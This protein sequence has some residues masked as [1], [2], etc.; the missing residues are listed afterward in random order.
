M[1]RNWQITDEV[2][3]KIHEPPLTGDHLGLKTWASSYL[4]AKR[5]ELIG[6]EH[7]IKNPKND[8]GDGKD[9]WFALELGSGTGLVGLA[10]AAVWQCCVTLTDLPEIVPNLKRNVNDNLDMIDERGGWGVTM[11]LDW[12]DPPF[13]DITLFRNFRVSCERLL[14]LIIRRH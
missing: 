10:A 14:N 6:A 4:L 8:T 1:T 9:T 5:L 13:H 2:T 3:L 7:Q 11:A 12:E